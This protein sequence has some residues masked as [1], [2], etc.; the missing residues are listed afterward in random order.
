MAD[1]GHDKT[2][3]IIAKMEKRL[4]KVYG[5][6]AE[7][8][9]AKLDKYLEDYDRKL[10]KKQ[11]QYKKG[12]IT[13]SEVDKWKRNQMAY[14]ASRKDLYNNLVSDMTNA[15]KIALSMINKTRSEVYAV[16]ANY[17][18]YE[19][20]TKMN[21]D[22]S[23]SLYNADAVERILT[24][25]PDLLP[26]PDPK[27][28]IPKSERWNKK[29]IQNEIMMG[30][31]QGEPLPKIETRL[32]NVVGMGERS[33]R[34]NARTAMTGAENAGRLRSYER[35]VSMG[36]EMQQEW[37][38][39]PDS[40]TRHSH[41]QLDGYC[42]D[43]G[44]EFP[45]GCRFPG[46]PMGDPAEVYNCRCVTRSVLKGHPY[47]SDW[48]KGTTAEGIDYKDWKISGKGKPIDFEAWEKEH[49]KK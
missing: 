24:E 8:M 29:H 28:V 37:I 46:D 34:T 9:Q 21:I 11:E 7:D 19:I 44:E 16:N 41:R 22:T 33:A 18:M 32:K 4:R 30:V 1:Y 45:N 40:R 31:L 48:R 12:Q 27:K 15:D 35:A 17:A 3:E 14:F 25:N 49:K 26:K 10:A 2:D 36:I 47:K 38:S 5:Q 6:A 20:E 23:F 43:V 42:V 39:T 13:K